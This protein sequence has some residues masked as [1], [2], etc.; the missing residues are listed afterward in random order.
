MEKFQEARDKAR[1][2]LRVADHM[3]Y[4]TYPLVKD[5]KLLAAILGN[6]FTAM[7]EGMSAVLYYDRLFKRIPP[8]H[9][10]FESKFNMFQ[11]KS[12][13]RHNIPTEH[14]VLIRDLRKVIADGKSNPEAF[15]R[16]DKFIMYS[17]DYG[18][19]N[20]NINLIKGYVER[21]KDFLNRVEE[22]VSKNEG[23]FK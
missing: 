19:R 15:A 8:F 13:I 3:L 1:Q 4:V 21:A 16:N 17:N 9:D 6:I 2:S 5:N 11:E 23:I 22:I 18:F 12:I 20:I 7:T 10:T 14:L